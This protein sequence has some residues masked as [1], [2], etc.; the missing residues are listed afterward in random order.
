[1][2][3][4]CA[5]ILLLPLLLCSCVGDGIK[6]KVT[7]F[8]DDLSH[9]DNL[10]FTASV[11]AE[12]DDSSERFTLSVS[13]SGEVYELTVTEPESIAGIKATYSSGDMSLGY[14]GFMLPLGD[15]GSRSVSPVSAAPYILDSAEG[16]YLRSVRREGEGC[17]AE[18]IPE[19]DTLITLYFTRDMTP[20]YAEIAFD[21]QVRIKCA[22][23]NW[24]TGSD[25]E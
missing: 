20:E 1:M 13:R 22:I 2:K 16:S 9:A 15:F 12:Y 17:A 5:A 24:N 8:S 18:F 23:S 4:L 7:D 19:D 21:G 25:G 14:D 10:S 3:K 6:D 11:T